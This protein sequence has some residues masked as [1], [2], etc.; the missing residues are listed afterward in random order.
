MLKEQI[1]SKYG[2]RIAKGDSD[3]S[4]R[5]C[6]FIQLTDKVGIKMYDYRDFRNET[7]EKQ[8]IAHK[9]GYAPKVLKKVNV[10]DKF[11]YLTELVDCVLCDRYNVDQHK[12]GRLITNSERDAIYRINQEV[13]DT[14]EEYGFTQHPDPCSFNFG[15]YKGKIVQIDFGPR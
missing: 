4:G 5:H 12:N 13:I 3:G 6:E 8:R 1:V 15:Y 7:V 2:D 14:L 10:G 11:G 9:H